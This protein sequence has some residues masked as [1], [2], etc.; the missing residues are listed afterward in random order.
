[1]IE[2]FLL[3]PQ[4]AFGEHKESMVDRDKVA[5]AQLAH[6]GDRLPLL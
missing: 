2:S 3:P 1:M 6:L 4:V 5:E